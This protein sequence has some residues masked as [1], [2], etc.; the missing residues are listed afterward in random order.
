[1]DKAALELCHR[2]AYCTVCFKHHQ[3]WLLYKVSKIFMILVISVIPGTS[4]SPSCL[5]IRLC[6]NHDSFVWTA[7]IE[8]GLQLVEPQHYHRAKSAHFTELNLPRASLT[9][10]STSNKPGRVLGSILD[11]GGVEWK[12]NIHTFLL[13]PSKR[14]MYTTVDDSRNIKS[15]GSCSFQFFLTPKIALMQKCWKTYLTI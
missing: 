8:P 14:T 10:F 1:M 3:F 7:G 4:L 13:W 15:S 9:L 6:Y 11:K 5:V 2:S 12:P